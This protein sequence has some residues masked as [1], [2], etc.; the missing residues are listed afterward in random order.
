MTVSR[1]LFFYC[2]S[3]LG[4]RNTY[5]YDANGNVSSAGTHSLQ[6]AYNLINLPAQIDSG[7][8]M[9]AGYTYLSDGTKA[10]ALDASGVG[11]DYLGSFTYAH[12]ANNNTTLESVAFGGGRVRK[13]GSGYDV[14]YYITD[15]L[16]SVRAIVN[17]SGTITEQNDY[18]PFGTRHPNGLTT[19]S[20]N[21]WRF[22]GKEEQDAS[23]GVPYSDFGARLY[24]RT[25][26]T[27]SDPLAEKYYAVSP[28]AYCNNNPVYYVD[29]DG[30]DGYVGSHGEYVWFNNKNDSFFHDDNGIEWTWVTDSKENW[31]EAIIIREANIEALVSLSFDLNA[32]SRDVRLY[33]GNSPLFT[34]ESYLEHPELYVTKWKSALNSASGTYDAF[35]SGEI[36]NSGLQLKYY[37]K[38]GDQEMTNSLGL[39]KSK[40][41]PHVYEGAVE[42]IERR[43]F[44]EVADMDPIYDMHV[45][46]AK[47][48]LKWKK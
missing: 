44:K 11:Y 36:G 8:I 20:G 13:N 43:L 10:R 34:K 21:R 12:D 16:G 2:I 28:Y 26:W 38:K 39:V 5:T 19:L 6:M 7:S 22:S 32:V 41:I 42:W 40:T 4:T 27:A 47:Q 31:D 29:I 14:D 15:H 35:V 30:Q 23:F 1:L 24:D 9:K 46:N 3:F 48:F 45:N 33:P 17:A 18:Y 37:T 25:A